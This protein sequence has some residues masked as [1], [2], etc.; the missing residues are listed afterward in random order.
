MLRTEENRFAER[1][2]GGEYPIVFFWPRAV[3]DPKP[4]F[5]VHGAGRAPSLPASLS[6]VGLGSDVST[7]THSLAA[8]APGAEIRHLYPGWHSESKKQAEEENGCA[9]LGAP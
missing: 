7:F 5:N 1:Q 9:D 8:K 2:L 3:L 6:T 4:T